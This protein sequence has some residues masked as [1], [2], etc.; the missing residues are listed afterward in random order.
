MSTIQ[1]SIETVLGMVLLQMPNG[2][3]YVFVEFGRDAGVFTVR[4]T[5]QSGSMRFKRERGCWVL[6]TE[7]YS[8]SVNSKWNG[9]NHVPSTRATDDRIKAV[10]VPAVIA[11]LEA[12]PEVIEDA[13]RRQQA[14]DIGKA[15]QAVE[16]TRAAWVAAV[17]ALRA[18]QPVI[19]A[20]EGPLDVFHVLWE[21][22]YDATSPVSAAR[23]AWADMQ[24]P[25]SI[26]NTFTVSA[27]DAEGDP[28]LS[29][30]IDLNAQE[31]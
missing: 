27:C 30:G 31:D 25:G 5:D 15:Q 12:H 19:T 10:V 20:A 1:H 3:D 14:K 23:K 13:R 8:F 6:G 4:G 17:H 28:I 26:A 18:L 22:D 11:W 9:K 24:R 7:P 2:A 21:C 16:G 29:V